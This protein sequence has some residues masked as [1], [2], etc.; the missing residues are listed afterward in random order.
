MPNSTS[1]EPEQ[2]YP[3]E[4]FTTPEIIDDCPECEP[5][6]T[7]WFEHMIRT[8]KDGEPNKA[9]DPSAATDAAVQWKRHRAEVHGEA[10]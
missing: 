4:P 8:T 10:E 7:D 1:E 2:P 5:F 3:F 6:V 9:Y